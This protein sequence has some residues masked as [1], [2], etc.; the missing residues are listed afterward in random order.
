MSLKLFRQ[1]IGMCASKMI[2]DSESSY[3]T[4]LASFASEA[5][6]QF[7]L[8]SRSLVMARPS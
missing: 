5:Y 6:M 7:F 1:E 2:L 8:S 3:H 4:L